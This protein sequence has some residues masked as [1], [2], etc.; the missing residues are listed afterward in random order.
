MQIEALGY[1]GVRSDQL[2]DW[3]TFASGFL[4][5]QI[6]E[7]SA[8]SLRLRMDDRRQRLV[9]APDVG[10]GPALFG[11]E[12]A[13]AAALESLAARLEAAQIEVRRG[14]GALATERRVKELIVFKDPIGT[15]L[16][17]FHG[18]EIAAE[19]FKPAR[20]ISGFR[21]GPLGVGHAVLAVANVE[22]LLPFY[23]DLLGFRLSDW[24]V[25]PFKAF[26]FHVNPR[27]HS[28]ALIETGRNDIHHFMIELYSLD[29]VGQGF[30]IAQDLQVPLG[31]TIGRHTN[32]F[33]TSF[34]SRTPSGFMVEY[35]WGGRTID[36]SSWQAG[37]MQHGGSLWG[38][39]RLWLDA[40]RRQNAREIQLRAAADGLRQPVQVLQGNYALSA[41][42]CPWWEQAKRQG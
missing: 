27:H 26:F 2:D 5:M 24:L 21:T 15:R 36:P 41:G 8:S 17:A 35:G 40:E 4:G 23:R 10:E 7:R 30:D 3:E 20:A 32:D 1:V 25:R 39:E 13:D 37:E 34:Y 11:W 16:E 31:T 33:M 22:V 9:V 38:H 42:V 28:L 6:D 14:T 19:P 29:D 18:A 12:L